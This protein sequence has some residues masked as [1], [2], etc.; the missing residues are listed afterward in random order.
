MTQ[1]TPAWT[2]D[3]AVAYEAARE[4]ITHMRAIITHEIDQEMHRADPNPSR[5][6]ALEAEDLRLHHERAALRV[7]DH[8]T[9]ARIRRDY[10]ARIREW[11]GQN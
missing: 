6:Q 5:L 8:D 2:Q 3:E 1:R 4:A 10:G 7:E 11:Q 9:I